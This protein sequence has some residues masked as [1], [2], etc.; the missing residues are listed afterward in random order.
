MGRVHRAEY[1]SRKSCRERELA[2]LQRVF[3]GIKQS[4][5]PVLMNKTGKN[6]VIQRGLTRILT[7]VLPRLWGLVSLKLDAALVPSNNLKSKLKRIVLF[8]NNQ[9]YLKIIIKNICRGSSCCDTSET[10]PTSIHEDVGLI[11]VLAQWVRDPLLP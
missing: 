3:L 11:P 8:T 2:G 6:I 10:N 5:D 4:I 9:L 7:R 1:Q